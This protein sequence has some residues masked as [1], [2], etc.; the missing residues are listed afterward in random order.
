[1][2][3]HRALMQI[4]HPETQIEETP[5]EYADTPAGEDQLIATTQRVGQDFFR[6]RR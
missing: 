4:E 6:E 1:M 5:F 2:T 3:A